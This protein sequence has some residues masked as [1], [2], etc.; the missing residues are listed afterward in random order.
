LVQIAS[1][2]DD[3]NSNAVLGAIVTLR[4]IARSGSASAS[5]ISNDDTISASAIASSVAVPVL[6]LTHGGVG[7]RD[8]AVRLLERGGAG[9]GGEH[10]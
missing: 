1:P 9:V 3:A 2:S 4:R 6:H 5:V 10:P 8:E 7:R